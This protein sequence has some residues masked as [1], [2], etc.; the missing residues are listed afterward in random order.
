M[1]NTNNQYGFAVTHTLLVSGVII[2]V[3]L[4]AAFISQQTS[5]SKQKKIYDEAEQQ[6]TAFVNEAAKLAP[7][8]KEIK[9]YCSYSSAKFSRGTLGC[10][11]RGGVT[12]NTLSSEISLNLMKKLDNLQEKI[13]WQY[14]KDNTWNGAGQE[15]REIKNSIYKFKN[16]TCGVVYSEAKTDRSKPGAP[17]ETQLILD[18]DCSGLAM[19]EYYHVVDY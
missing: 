15:T 12:Y 17:E 8:A 9:K 5:T 4:I 6:I 13:V 11:V 14:D 3:V 2:G 10:S 1:H 18:I 16:L 19:Q 7:S